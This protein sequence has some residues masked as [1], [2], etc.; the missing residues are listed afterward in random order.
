MGWTVRRSQQFCGRAGDAD[1][2]VTE[3]PD[4]FVEC[5]LV[6]VLNITA[7][8]KK[9]VEDAGAALPAVFHRRDREEWL[10]TIRLTDLPRLVQMITPTTLRKPWAGSL[11]PLESRPSLV[12]ASDPESPNDST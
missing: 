10:M 9:A 5:K 6:Q 12:E 7:A 1:L 11:P 2:L 4:L 3:H 8:V